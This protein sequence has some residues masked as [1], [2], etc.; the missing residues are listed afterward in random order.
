[1]TKNIEIV[2]SP[3]L[4]PYYHKCGTV[5]LIDVL[6][7]TSTITTAL[8]HGALSAET[9]GSPQSVFEAKKS[10]NDYIFVGEQNGIIIPG[11]DYN[12]SPVAMTP[13]N[14]S[15]RKLAFVT[16]NGTYMRSLIT[17]AES[18]YAG[19]FLNCKALAD[20]LINEFEDVQL[21]CSGGRNKPN[22][23]DSLFA[24]MLAD[25]LVSSGKFSFNSV[26]VMMCMLLYNNAKDDLKQYALSHSKYL[27][28]LY[29]TNMDYR[30]DLDF[31]FNIDKFGIVPEEEKP[32][33][34]VLKK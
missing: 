21:I 8:A 14:I 5:V 23:E 6:R 2:L 26:S 18:V 17:D 3:A 25:R 19:C 20:R 16:T 24:G 34:F 22:I 10:D 33:I 12:N 9:F 29:N 31:S 4:Y 32:Y 7:C 1:M 28:D 15:N 11:F 30:A 13:Q 27:L